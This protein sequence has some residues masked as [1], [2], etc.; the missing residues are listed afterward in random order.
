MLVEPPSHQLKIPTCTADGMKTPTSCSKQSYMEPTSSI[1]IHFSKRTNRDFSILINNQIAENN[2]NSINW[3]GV[4]G[5]AVY[6]DYIVMIQG[7][8]M[9]GK[10]YITITFQP[11]FESR[12]EQFHATLIA[13]E[14]FKL[15]NPDNNLA[16]AGLIPELQHSNSTPESKKSKPS[17][18]TNLISTVLIAKLA[19]LNVAVYTLI[20]FSDSSSR[21]N[22]GSSL[23]EDQCRQVYKGSIDS[24]A[25]VV[26]I[27]RLKTDTWQG[28]TEF[29]TEIKMLSKLRHVHLVLLIGYCNDGEERILVY[30]YITKGTLADHIYKANTHG[31]AN[32]P[33]PW[34]LRLKVSI[35]AAR[36]LCYLH[37]RHRII[38]RDIKSSNILLDDNW[39]AKISDFGLSKM[40]PSNDSCSHLTTNVKVTY[41]YLD[42]QYLLTRLRFIHSTV[43][44]AML[45]R[46]LK[47]TNIWSDEN[48]IP[49]GSGWGLSKKKGIN[50]VQS[51]IRSNWGHLDSDYV[52][53][54][55]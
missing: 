41:G 29:Q 49:K 48:W 43:Q 18:H 1:R 44:Q 36:G 33:L 32:P 3:G 45:H 5:V 26:A 6:R 42:P 12:D 8:N 40:G 52:H 16:G 10:C 15:S 9:E 4:S 7:D 38:H 20:K 46:D 28:E 25:T 50:Q 47:S 27:K 23:V 51:I 34:E 39:V 24:G 13:L 55:S 21:R 31:R 14:V 30:K 11:K 19:L 54:K 53:G 22:M 35:G 2:A 17:Y 37:S